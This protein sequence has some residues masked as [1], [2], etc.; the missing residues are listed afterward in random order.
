MMCSFDL[1]PFHSL[2]QN[3]SDLKEGRNIPHLKVEEKQ[4]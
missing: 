2:V 4:D 1:L 3:K